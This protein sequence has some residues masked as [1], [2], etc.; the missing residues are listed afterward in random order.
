MSARAAVR[1]ALM[2]C[3][4]VLTT[5]GCGRSD[6][7][8]PEQTRAQIAALEKERDELRGRFDALVISDK[9]LQG[10]PETPVRIGVPTTLAREL[11]EKVTAG[12]V[13]QVTL[14]LTNLKVKKS[15]TVKKVF[16]IGSYDLFVNIDRVTGQLKTAK[17][18]VK[19][20]GNSVTVALPVKV[21]SG[22]GQATIRFKWDGK[23]V[24]GAACGDLEVEQVVSGSVKPNRYPV[25]G[26]LRLEATAERI[27]ASPRFPPLKVKLEIE[28]SKESWAA[29]QAILD[30]KTGVCGFAVD[31]I[32]VLGL[33]RG[34]VSKGFDVRLP[35]EKIKP[36]AIP[37]GIEPSMNVQG[38][39]VALDIRVGGLA[40]TEHV[41]WLGANVAVRAPAAPE[42]G[43]APAVAVGAAPGT[44]SA[45]GAT[46]PS[47]GKAK[48]S[49]PR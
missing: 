11:I 6:R 12:F 34:I 22:G 39:P 38:H 25:S 44:A 21:A 47:A 27:L 2:P 9:R 19:F 40:I 43:A 31:K 49:P 17:P 45:P 13:D 10:M 37:V 20:G 26:T 33:V 4:L 29:V 1:L 15:G 32:D 35:T 48:A 28:P 3:L 46:E 18:E 23:N 5:A 30:S 24:S 8:T 41:I 7:A 14:Q 42:G 16:T 36:M